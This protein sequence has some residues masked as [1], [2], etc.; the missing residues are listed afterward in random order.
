MNKK[1]SWKLLHQQTGM[2]KIQ[3]EIIQLLDGDKLLTDKQQNAN[4]LST[5]SS[6]VAFN[7]NDN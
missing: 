6:D 4:D 1:K 3:Y 2:N 5:F 7:L